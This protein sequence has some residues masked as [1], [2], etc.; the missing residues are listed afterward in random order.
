MFS[1]D[2][3]REA[4]AAAGQAGIDPAAL[5]AVMEVESGGRLFA[6][7]Q[8]RKEPLIRFEGHYFDRRLSGREQARARQLGLAAP[9]AGAIPNPSTQSAR[10]AL[11]GKAT[12]IDANAAYESTSWGIGQVMGAHWLWLGFPNVQA[13]VVEARSGAAGQIRLMVRYIDKAGLTAALNKQNWSVFARG[14]N[15]PGYA[16]NG[17]DRKLAAAYRRRV[18]GTVPPVLKAGS[19]GDFVK[20][21]QQQLAV[22]GYRLR[23]DGIFGPA[24]QAAVRRFQKERGL[25]VDGIAGLRTLE[26]LNKAIAPEKMGW[27]AAM[28][29]ILAR[30]FGML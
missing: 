1:E 3:I 12:Q 18:S 6:V 5:L 16:R 13:L 10:W 4:Q 17:Y 11:L 19:R 21:L 9:A 22:L 29:M 8:G 30:W 24:T 7:V 14:Y 26:A 20:A 25:V 27:W 2:V 23:A 15:G 28:K